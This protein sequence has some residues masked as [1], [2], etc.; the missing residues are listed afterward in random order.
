[1]DDSEGTYLGRTVQKEGFRVFVYAKNDKR[2][3]VN[4]WD[5]FIRHVETGEWFSSPEELQATE[6][7]DEF[8]EVKHAGKKAR[9]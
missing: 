6:E 7:L 5:E 2:K 4:S 8:E 9:K 1:M 3:L